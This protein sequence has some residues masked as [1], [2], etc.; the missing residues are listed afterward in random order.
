MTALKTPPGAS[1]ASEQA[2]QILC[3]DLAAAALAHLAAEIERARLRVAH[4]SAIAQVNLTDAAQTAINSLATLESAR[5]YQYITAVD[6]TGESLHDPH[7]DSGHEL[8]VETL[9]IRRAEAKR[10]G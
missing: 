4:G 1:R 3:R 10:H 8:M 6:Q 7:Y 5:R 9:P 2:F